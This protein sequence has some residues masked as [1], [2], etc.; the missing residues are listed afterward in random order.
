M[1][2][3]DSGLADVLTT[4]NFH[5]AYLDGEIAVLTREGI[6][7]FGGF[8][9]ALGRHGGSAKLTC[10]AFESSTA[11]AETSGRCRSSNARRSWRNCFSKLSAGS[12]VQYSSH[13]TRRCAE[14]FSLACRRHLE[15][16]ISKRGPA[17]SI[18]PRQGLGEDQMHLLP[19]V[20]DRR[21]PIRSQK[22]AKSGLS[23]YRLLRWGKLIYAGSVG[24]GWSV[25]LGRSIMA[26]L[27]RIGLDTSPF[28]A[29][30]R[31]DAKDAHWAE[32]QLVCEVEFTQWTRDGR[33]RQP[34]FGCER[35]SGEG[36]A[37]GAA[38][39]VGTGGR[40][41]PSPAGAGA[42]PMP[43]RRSQATFGNVP[44]GTSLGLIGRVEISAG[45][46]FGIRFPV[47]STT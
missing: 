47:I 14:F 15:G 9:E 36:C 24:T 12:P 34:A 4:L 1:G 38:E 35:T 17:L 16:I 18:G 6:S 3:Q 19:G 45:R 21:L 13:V 23:S 11:T 10:V 37:A 31:P 2:R 26:A 30:P 42:L 33:V 44:S 20:L 29:V 22:P 32:P 5:S 43:G 7:D 41:R 39:A 8:Q 27:Q 40:R 25:Q 28:V 46:A